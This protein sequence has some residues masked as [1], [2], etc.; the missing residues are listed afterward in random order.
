M[1]ENK[2]LAPVEGSHI[3]STAFK[4][5][6]NSAAEF[7]IQKFTKLEKAVAGYDQLPESKIP[8]KNEEIRQ[9]VS[10][11]LDL[12][13]LAQRAMI[14]YWKQMDSDKS[15]SKLKP[16]YLKLFQQL[17]EENYLEKAREYVNS[18][19]Q[20]PLVKVEDESPFFHILGKIKKPDVDLLVDFK[21]LQAKDGTYHVVDVKLDET[22]LESTYRSSFNRIIRKKD[23]L[24]EGFPELLRVM[25]KRLEELKKGGATRL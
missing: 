14:T 25:E 7:L 4:V 16:K 10:S 21:I 1:D 6:S 5:E 22:S 15:L 19:Y 23:G 11:T 17:V 3:L 13:Y 12:G 9:I 20:I 2:N 24:K 18:K 8:A